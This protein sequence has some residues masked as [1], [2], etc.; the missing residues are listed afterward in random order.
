MTLRRQYSRGSPPPV[1]KPSP[2]GG[3][4]IPSAA[5]D[6][7]TWDPKSSSERTRVPTAIVADGVAVLV[8]TVIWTACRGLLSGKLPTARC[9]AP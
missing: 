6:V 9:D 7:P 5:W 2:A 3:D 8:V 1:P 4:D